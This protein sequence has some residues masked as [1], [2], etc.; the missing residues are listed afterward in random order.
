MTDPLLI[1]ACAFFFVVAWP[2]AIVA[3]LDWPVDGE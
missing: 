2:I 1:G 3:T